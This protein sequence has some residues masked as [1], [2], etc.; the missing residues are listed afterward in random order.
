MKN[1]ITSAVIAASLLLAGCGKKAASPDPKSQGAAP[2]AQPAMTAWQ[3]GDKPAAISS[4]AQADW[5]GRPL[6]APGSGLSLSE[7]QFKRLS[8]TERQAA[9]VELQS[10]L[11]TLKQLTAAVA[12]AGRDAAAKG[13]KAQAQKYFTSLQQCGTALQSPDCLI[14]V[15]LVGKA[16]KKVGDS[17]L[18]KVGQ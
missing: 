16:V 5:T 2:V 11:D 4:F 13:D 8:A 12:Q 15:Q 3:Q 9:S 17:E 7:D 1:A 18:A 14:L 6:F 10:Q